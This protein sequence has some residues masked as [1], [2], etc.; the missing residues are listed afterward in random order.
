MP[1]CVQKITAWFNPKEQRV[2]LST[3]RAGSVSDRSA[4]PAGTCVLRSLTLPV[5]LLLPGPEPCQNHLWKGLEGKRLWT[6]T[7]RGPF[8]AKEGNLPS[9]RIWHGPHRKGC[10]NR[11][12]LFKGV[13][14]NDASFSLFWSRAGSSS[15]SASVP[16]PAAFATT[17]CAS[18]RQF[19]NSETHAHLTLVFFWPR[20]RWLNQRA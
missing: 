4:S 11:N 13:I 1:L 10:Q 2:T 18:P 12:G 17:A 6:G 16:A 3:W 19:G 5:R 14:G 15:A 20:K 8:G 9:V 7:V